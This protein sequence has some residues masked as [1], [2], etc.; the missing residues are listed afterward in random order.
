VNE[1]QGLIAA[2]VVAAVGGYLSPLVVRRLPEPPEKPDE[3]KT[4]HELAE[5]PKEP[6]A[7]VGDLAWF[8]PT[9]MAVSGLAG[10]VVGWTYGWSWLLLV[11]VPVIP[12]VVA[13]SLVDLRTRLLPAIVVWPTLLYALVAVVAH[14]GLVATWDD[15][16]RAVVA[17]VVGYVF[18]FVLWFVYPV[19]LGF[20]DVRLSAVLAL[21]LGYLGWP[22][23]AVGM[24]SGFLLLGLPGLALAIAKRRLSYLRTQFPFGPFMAAGALVGIAFGEALLVR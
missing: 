12:V 6:Y 9:A 16:R 11:L 22:Q 4:E 10:A 23:F 19:G 17:M 18:Y 7:V 21:L 5:G 1:V 20:G 3:D 24:Y 8:A 15:L 13:L 14:A 2:A